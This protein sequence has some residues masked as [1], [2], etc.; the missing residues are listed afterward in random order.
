MAKQIT[1]P[2]PPKSQASIPLSL[3]RGMTRIG[4]QHFRTHTSQQLEDEHRK[5]IVIIQLEDRETNL[6]QDFGSLG[7][8]T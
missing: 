1:K 3:W 4:K 8:K 6:K 7:R 5:G 2:Q